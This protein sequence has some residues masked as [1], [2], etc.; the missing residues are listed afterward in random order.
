MLHFDIHVMSSTTW[1]GD[2][3]KAALVHLL[4]FLHVTLILRHHFIDIIET[5]LRPPCCVPSST[6]SICTGGLGKLDTL[7]DIDLE[8]LDRSLQQFLFGAVC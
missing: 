4:F 3:R 7:V 1:H 8:T 6:D 2:W 5:A